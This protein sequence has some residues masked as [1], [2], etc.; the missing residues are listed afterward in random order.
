[1]NETELRSYLVIEISDL[2]QEVYEH[3][4]K[5]AELDFKNNMF[6]KKELDKIKTRLELEFI[7]TGYNKDEPYKETKERFFE[8]KDNRNDDGSLGELPR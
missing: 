1:M 2:Y 5:I 8:M 7:R 3:K 4:L 6:S